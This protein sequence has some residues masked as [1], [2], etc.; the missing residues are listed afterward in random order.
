MGTKTSAAAMKRQLQESSPDL[1]EVVAGATTLSVVL[2]GF[3][4]VRRSKRLCCSPVDSCSP[5]TENVAA[6]QATIRLT[7]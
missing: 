6:M 5:A 4:I 7:K 1:L 3:Y 2:G